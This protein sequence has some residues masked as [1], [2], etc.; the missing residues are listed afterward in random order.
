MAAG[1]TIAA[2][3][4]AMLRQRVNEYA[5]ENL[6]WDALQP[7]LLADAEVELAEVDERLVGSLSSIA[8]FGAGNPAPLLISR[9]VLLRECRTVGNDNSHI[10]LAVSAQ[11]GPGVDCIGFGLGS[12][13]AELLQHFGPVD[14]AFA[15]EINE[16]NGRRSVQLVLSD[17]KIQEVPLSAV[18]ALFAAAEEEADRYADILGADEFY[19]KAVGVTF[20][21]RQERLAALIPGQPLCLV[22]QPDNPHDANAILVRTEQE[23][24]IG[25]LNADLA[26]HLA[27]AMDEGAVYQAQVAS[28]TGGD[29]RAYGVNLF[30]QREPCEDEMIERAEQVETRRQ[31]AYLGETEIWEQIRGSLLGGRPFRPKQEEA[32]DAL[33]QGENTLVVMGTGRGKSAIFQGFG[34]YQA[35]VHDKITVIVYPLRALVNDQLDS[36]RRRLGPLGLRVFKATGSL[37][38]RER[39]ELAMALALG[40][41]DFVLATPEFIAANLTNYPELVARVGLFVVDESHHIGKINSNRTAYR[42]LDQLRDWLGNPLTLAVTATASDE[43]ADEVRAMLSISR[44]VIDPHI[45]TNLR[46]SDRRGI[47]D[48]DKLRLLKDL[49]KTGD[50]AVVYVNSRDGAVDLARNL[51]RDNL[52]LKDCVG[53]YH[54]GLTNTQR[55]MVEGLF[56]DGQLRMIIATSAFG[57]G[58]DIPDI[59]HVVHY[60]LTF[61]ETDF[62][63]QSGRAG[64]DGEPAAI[65]LCYNDR[66]LELNRLILGGKA[67]D[68]ETLRHI[69]LAL[70]EAAPVGET[71]EATN[72][73]LAELAAARAEH[74]K[75]NARAITDDTVSVA[76]GIFAE[77]DLLERDRQ[78]RDRRIRLMARPE[79][80]LDLTK[81]IRY[82]E[83]IEEKEAFESFQVKACRA[84]S[85]ELLALINRPI[86]PS[87]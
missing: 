25:Y 55:V 48:R 33:R 50:K 75:G 13:A 61:N 59:R 1:L 41:V 69:Y 17:I 20:E 10:K 36:V 45:R 34:A 8:P 40:E 11:S 79:K 65:H 28:V 38:A 15:P 60:H 7:V 66:D 21:D 81:S 77:L 67:P 9:G 62:N 16:W 12:M 3:Q 54:G 68:R 18:D 37:G 32:I 2:D 85:D 47:S 82:N 44:T 42:R 83:G 43:V 24:E 4:V 6:P 29:D 86:C 51:R 74:G 58:I 19:T 5:E 76:L 64:R 31:L 56:R 23:V 46:I 87:H 39:E 78:G 71:V 63:Q 53:F 73:A 26:R 49:L 35:L 70:M 84:P 22:R 57:E 30:I 52:E 72:Q 27:K 80:K 14:V